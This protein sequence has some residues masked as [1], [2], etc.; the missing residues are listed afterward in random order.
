MV[1]SKANHIPNKAPNARPALPP[2]FMLPT[3]A[4]AE[5]ISGAPLPNASSVT[6]CMSLVKEINIR[7]I[8]K[9]NLSVCNGY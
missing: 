6:P 1:T 5:N 7:T 3:A 9:I 8:A 2:L 4:N